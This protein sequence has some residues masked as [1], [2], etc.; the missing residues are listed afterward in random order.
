MIL[1]TFGVQVGPLEDGGGS[2]GLAY[3]L[4]LSWLTSEPLLEV[5]L[6]E[7]ASV[8]QN[9]RNPNESQAAN[10]IFTRESHSSS[11]ILVFHLALDSWAP[12]P[13]PG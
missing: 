8:Y 6:F 9:Y 4:T 1:R 3:D 11:G 5:Q 13:D 10:M 2:V 12:S 7:T